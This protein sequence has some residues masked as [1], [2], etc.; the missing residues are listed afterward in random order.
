MDAR[1]TN[2]DKVLNLVTNLS[3]SACQFLAESNIRCADNAATP[4]STQDLELIRIIG[5]GTFARVWLCRRRTAHILLSKTQT[6]FVTP[7]LSIIDVPLRSKSAPNLHTQQT[8]PLS[9]LPLEN[10]RSQSSFALQTR[11]VSGSPARG[12]HDEGKRTSIVG[13]PYYALKV[14][15]AADMV[16]LRQVGH[17]LNERA[18]LAVVDHHFIARLYAFYCFCRIQKY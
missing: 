11:E 5:T 16:R 15:R 1:K 2:Q 14:M 7:K 6:V 18:I 10:R 4:H 3:S 9:K 8:T 13:E 17:V 12:T